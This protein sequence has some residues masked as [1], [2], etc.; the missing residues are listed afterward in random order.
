MADAMV[1]SS[2]VP[3]FE[4]KEPSE[5]PPVER[6]VTFPG[7]ESVSQ[8]FVEPV[9]KRRRSPAQTRLVAADIERILLVLQSLENHMEDCYFLLQELGVHRRDGPGGECMVDD[10][11]HR[12]AWGETQQDVNP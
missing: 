9:K 6:S 10:D 4:P 8:M 1:S 5:A 3:V 7:Q 12:D 11:D 2:G